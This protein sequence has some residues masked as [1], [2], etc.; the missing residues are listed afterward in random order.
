MLDGL[1]LS[2]LVGCDEGFSC[3]IGHF[4]DSTVADVE[5]VGLDLSSVYQGNYKSIGDEWSELFHQ[6]ESE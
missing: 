2:V 1:C 6:V 4:D 3:I 5:V